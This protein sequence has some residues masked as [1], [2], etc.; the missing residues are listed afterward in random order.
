MHFY[1]SEYQSYDS[2][3]LADI[4][5]EQCRGWYYLHQLL[6]VNWH[7]K[8]A[9]YSD[10]ISDLQTLMKKQNKF[11]GVRYEQ[12]KNKIEDEKSQGITYVECP[13]C[14]FPACKL[15]LE[16]L[17]V[18]NTSCLVCEDKSF[19]VKTTCP[20]CHTNITID[21]TFSCPKCKNILH[22]SDIINTLPDSVDKWAYCDNC[23]VDAIPTI[24]KIGSMWFCFSCFTK[25]ENRDVGRCGWCGETVTGETGN[26]Y[27]PGCFMCAVHLQRE[28]EE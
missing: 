22:F 2:K 26:Y 21:K 1:H 28:S 10:E 16:E 15:G 5:A 6:T 20:E 18:E 12:I 13:S 9:S 19:R 27:N 4:A 25:Y 7:S 23:K 11:L 8:F 24:A 17:G 3:L 14:G